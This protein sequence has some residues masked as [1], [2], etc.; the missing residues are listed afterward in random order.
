MGNI[1][2]IFCNKCDYKKD[3]STGAGMMY[4]SLDNIAFS[5]DKEYSDIFNMRAYLKKI[6]ENVYERLQESLYIY[7]ECK[8]WDNKLSAIFI[9]RNDDKDE[10]L[11]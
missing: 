7:D 1:S 3:I 11:I 6:Y 10:D 4:G 8:Y 9:A 2:R 5:D